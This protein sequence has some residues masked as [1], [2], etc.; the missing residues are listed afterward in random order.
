MTSYTTDLYRIHYSHTAI[1]FQAKTNQ[2]SVIFFDELD[3][4]APA[5][6][7]Q[8]DHVY[9]TIVGALLTL[10]DGLEDRQQVTRYGLVCKSVSSFEAY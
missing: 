7:S 1:L 3:A 4:L 10:L 6:N 2:P 5:R 9:T 8:Q